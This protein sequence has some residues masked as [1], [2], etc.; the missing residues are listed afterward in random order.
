MSQLSLTG[1][2]PSGAGESAWWLSGGIAA[3]NCI[4]A[5]TSKGAA[6]LAASY[7]NNAAPHNGLPDGTYDAAPGVAPTWASGTGWTFAEASGQYLTTGYTVTTGS[8]ISAIVAFSNASGLYGQIVGTQTSTAFRIG[9]RDLGARDYRNGGIVSVGT[10]TAAGTMAIAGS[11]A[12]FN[13]AEEG[14]ITVTVGNAGVLTIAALNNAGTP[15]PR[16]TG[17]IAALAIYNTALSA[18]QVA[19]VSAAMAAL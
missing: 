8:N 1:A 5:Y 19:A 2:G 15:L 3:A 17:N 4:A 7:D 12:Y 9:C 18:A 16:Y 10:S 13:G 6:S 14:T 11:K